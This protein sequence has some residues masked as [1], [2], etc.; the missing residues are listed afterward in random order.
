MGSRQEDKEIGKENEKAR[1]KGQ[2][3]KTEERRNRQGNTVRA[4]GKEGI[5]IPV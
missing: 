1:E 4:V 5:K 2:I 3:R